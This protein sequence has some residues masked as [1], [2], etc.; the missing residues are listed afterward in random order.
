[1]WIKKLYISIV[2]YNHCPEKQE[3][4]IECAQEEMLLN[5]ISLTSR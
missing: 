5:K 1:M 4:E 3:Y 2:S